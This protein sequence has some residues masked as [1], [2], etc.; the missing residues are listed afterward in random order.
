LGWVEYYYTKREK[1][2]EAE[3]LALRAIELNPLKD[4]IYRDTLEK[5]REMRTFL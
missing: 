2:D 4:K 5:V 3:N 1:L